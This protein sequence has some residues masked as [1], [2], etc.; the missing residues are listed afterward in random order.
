MPTETIDWLPGIN[1]VFLPTE[2]FIAG[3]SKSQLDLPTE[4]IGWLPDV[5]VVF[6]PTETVE[7]SGGST[8]V[9]APTQTTWPFITITAP[10]TSTTSGTAA[11][12]HDG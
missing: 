12:T 10:I 5:T 4:T 11:P 6:A 1:V 2:T 7:Y 8:W 3:E 9:I